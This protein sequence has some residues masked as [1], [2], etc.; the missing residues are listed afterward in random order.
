[1]EPR[2]SEP[3][4]LARLAE[5]VS[6]LEQAIGGIA[7]ILEGHGALLARLLEAAEEKPPEETET[8]RLLKALVGRVGSA[9]GHAAEDR[10]GDRGDWQ[11][12][13]ENR[14]LAAIAVG[15]WM[16]PAAIRNKA[17]MHRLSLHEV[18]EPANH[19][20]TGKN[21]NSGNRHLS[22]ANVE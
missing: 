13:W 14:R 8:Q 5:A 16:T 21:G 1:M 17:M 3:G 22:V 2:M 15:D 19:D 12:N 4:D 6:G 20:E 9:A 11:L 10:E 7:A 18:A